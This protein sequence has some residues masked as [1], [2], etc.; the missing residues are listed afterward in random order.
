MT[1]APGRLLRLLSL[2]QSP[3]EWPGA[4]LADR[5]GVS[6]R[7]VRRDVD[8]LR[9]LGY[10]VAATMGA[11]G[12][13]RLIAGTAMPPL[14]LDDDEAVAVA[15]AL[16]T[17]AADAIAGIDEAALRAGAK[18]G[19]VLPARLR[20]RVAVLTAATV[21]LADEHEPV[22]D[23]GTL[24]TLAATV[25]NRERARFAYRAADGAET[26]R[27]VEPFRLVPA[28]R[29][30]YLVAWD[31][32]RD[33]WRIFRVDRIARPEAVGGRAASRALPAADAAQFV[34]QSFH[35]RTPVF[36]AVV[37]LHAPAA[38]MSGRLSDPGDG[39]E[40][41]D[42]DSC[43]LRTAPDTLEWLAAR[44][45]TLGVDFDVREPPELAA[46]LRAMGERAVQASAPPAAAG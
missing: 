17:V 19:Q 12:G 22:V 21:P 27:S 36:R 5:L 40:R 7:T 35:G 24:A 38:A 39:V 4:E 43:L 14:L 20:R 6:R 44:L 2:L 45:L 30:W 18:L 23:P 31:L 46:C 29:R 41:I 16:G 37:V 42:D 25:A 3:R 33:D 15:V 1:A 11:A 26:K 9:D 28:W 32:D 8:R 13:Y 34:L 10:P